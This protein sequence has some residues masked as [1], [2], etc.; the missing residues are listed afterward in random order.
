M[1]SPATIFSEKS[2]NGWPCAAGERQGKGEA[3][4]KSPHMWAT[5]PLPEHKQFGEGRGA[6]RRRS[7]RHN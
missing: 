3:P 6:S 1:R 4:K 5:T 2:T 7:A